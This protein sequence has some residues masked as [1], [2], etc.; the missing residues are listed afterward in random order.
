MWG[1]GRREKRDREGRN[2]EKD[3]LTKR[4]V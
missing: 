2:V 3:S 1:I 4:N